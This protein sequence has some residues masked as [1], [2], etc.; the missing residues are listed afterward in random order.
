MYGSDHS[1][2][3]PPPLPV[4][5]SLMLATGVS[6]KGTTATLADPSQSSPVSKAA[7]AVLIS[8][9]PVCRPM[10]VFL[11]NGL[12][13]CRA[14]G[15]HYTVTAWEETNGSTVNLCVSLPTI[16]VHLPTSGSFLD[17]SDSVRSGQSQGPA[18]RGLCSSS[19]RRHCPY[20]ERDSTPVLSDLL[21]HSSHLAPAVSDGDDPLILN[22]L[23][24]RLWACSV[25]LQDAY[26]HVPIF[27]DHSHFLT[28]RYNGAS[29]R[30]T[31]LPFGLSTAP[32]T[33]A[34]LVRTLAAFL[35]LLGVQIFVYL[36]DWLSVAE[37]REDHVSDIRRVLDVTSSLGWLINKENSSL[38]PSQQLTYLRADIDLTGVGLPTREKVRAVWRGLS[39]LHRPR[40]VPAR[41]V[42]LASLV[43]LVPHAAYTCGLSCS[44]SP[45]FRPSSQDLTVLVPP[46]RHL[47]QIFQWV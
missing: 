23:P 12:C 33:F 31:A 2:P 1:P 27:M 4:A 16:G 6:S 10:R 46:A 42:Y 29:Y 35:R 21:P 43:D 9:R 20:V 11:H 45:F 39:I 26:L 40:P 3:P 17:H 28:F 47:D 19:E 7:Q 18:R 44:T 22:R 14:R 38:V 5:P 24:P 36:E 32:R 30:F 37:S 13:K 15:P 8:R 34:R 25:D 41:L